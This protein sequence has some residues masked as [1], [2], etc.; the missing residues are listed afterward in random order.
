[1]HIQFHPVTSRSVDLRPLA[2]GRIA[3]GALFVLRTTPLLIPLR[4]PFATGTYPLLGWPTASWHGAAIGLVL[5]AGVLKAACIVRTLGALGFMLGIG[6]RACG[7]VA[8]L[9]GYLVMVQSPFGFVA[10]L[11]LLFQG[12]LVLAL[13]DAGSVLALRPERALTGE[14]GFWLVRVFMASIYF[15]AGVAKL[16][17]DWL[18][19]RTFLLFQGD[20]AL[21]GPFSDFVLATGWSRQLVACFIAATELSLPI[22]LLWRKTA[23]VAPWLAL[24]MHAAIELAARPDLLGWEMAAMLLC[25]WPVGSDPES[26]VDANATEPAG[27]MRSPPATQ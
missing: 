24:T 17:R 13:T 3:L 2:W 11:H 27:T 15:W 5:P 12:C 20:G 8:A 7:L 21:S 6:T 18:S 1:L 22:L 14:S 16:N 9:T 19:G 10:T 26:V 25:L 23:R 4:L